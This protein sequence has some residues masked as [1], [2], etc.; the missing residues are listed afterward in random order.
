MKISRRLILAL[1]LLPHCKMQ[2]KAILIDVIVRWKGTSPTRRPQ[3]L[4]SSYRP[5]VCE[6]AYTTLSTQYGAVHL[7]MM[8]LRNIALPYTAPSS[9]RQFEARVKPATPGSKAQYYHTRMEKCRLINAYSS[10]TSL[11]CTKASHRCTS[12]MYHFRSF[13]TLLPA[14]SRSRLP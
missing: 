7:V 3:S 2:G 8:V 9:P 5:A 4:G 1:R 12:H 6:T 11:W 10:T 14:K 13:L